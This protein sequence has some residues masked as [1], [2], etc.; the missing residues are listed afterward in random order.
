MPSRSSIPL[1]RLSLL[2]PFVQELDRRGVN[3]N[4]VLAANGVIRGS[5]LDN[6]VFVTPITVH[7]FLE[8]AAHAANDRY[9]GVH[10]GESLDWTGWMPVLEA[11][12]KSRNLAGFLVRFIRAV[13]SEASSARHE[14]DIGS[15]YAV[16]KERRTTEQE[17]APAQND[18]FTATYILSMLCKAAG[19][20]W[21]PGKVRLTV[22]DPKA[23]PKRYLGTH[24]MG[25]DRMGVS[26]R[27]PSAWLL[28]QFNRKSFLKVDQ[29]Q[30]K[31]Q[32]MPVQFLDALRHVTFQHLD[33]GPLDLASTAKLVGISK[34]SLQRR[35]RANGTTLSSVIRELK[36]QKA[37]EALLHTDQPISEIAT[38]LQFSSPTSFARAFKAWTGVSPREFRK[39]YRG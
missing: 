32:E 22:C 19:D 11:A 23:L 30:A 9:F 31:Q 24:I 17:I 25:G 14:L 37:I 10:V 28:E 12:T 15:E 38:A 3:T 33:A 6:S 7:R 36:K 18:A 20:V 5:L 39:N 2:M 35:L 13:G 1:V 21:D 34:Q 8:D 16:F 26:V 27:F 29:G 4:A